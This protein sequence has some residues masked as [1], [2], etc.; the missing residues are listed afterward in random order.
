MTDNPA[1]ASADAMTEEVLM[2]TRELI[3]GTYYSVHVSRDGKLRINTGPDDQRPD[4][5]GLKCF[6]PIC[7]AQYIG[8]SVYTYV[9]YC[10]HCRKKMGSLGEMKECCPRC[11]SVVAHYVFS[12]GIVELRPA[13]WSDGLPDQLPDF[14][15]DCRFILGSAE[16]K[17][18]SEGTASGQE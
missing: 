9:K 6:R 17:R 3:D 5:D 1:S 7:V 14:Q 11:G 4:H 8:D 2:P 10:G 15:N 13:K 12:M 16:R 18:S